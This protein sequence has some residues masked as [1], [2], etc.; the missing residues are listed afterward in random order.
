[1]VSPGACHTAVMVFARLNGS[2]QLW[3]RMQSLSLRLGHASSCPSHAGCVS[4]AYLLLAGTHCCVTAL[5]TLA[6]FAIHVLFMSDRVSSSFTSV[7]AVTFKVAC[8][9]SCLFRT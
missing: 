8:Q 7:A 2:C 3:A 9:A 6:F 1:M 5:H 4:H